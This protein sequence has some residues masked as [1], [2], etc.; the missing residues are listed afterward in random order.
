MVEIETE[1]FISELPLPI[2]DLNNPGDINDVDIDIYHESE[3]NVQNAFQPPIQLQTMNNTLSGNSQQNNLQFPIQSQIIA[4]VPLINPQKNVL[5]SPI[6]SQ[7]MGNLSS[8]NLQQNTLQPA[9]QSQNTRGIPI[10]SNI[11]VKPIIFQPPSIS[12][13][14][15][16]N[17]SSVSSTSSKQLPSPIGQINIPKNLFQQQI[18]SDKVAQVGNKQLSPIIFNQQIKPQQTSP[19]IFQQQS[20]NEQKINIFQPPINPLEIKPQNKILNVNVQSPFNMIKPQNISISQNQKQ[21]IEQIDNVPLIDKISMDKYT[22]EDIKLFNDNPHIRQL[23]LIGEKPT[24]NYNFQRTMTDDYP[25]LPYIPFTK[26]VKDANPTISENE[27]EENNRDCSLRTVVHWGQRKLLISEIEFLTD[28]L[29]IDKK[30]IVV[31]VGAAPGTHITY[32]YDLFLNVEFHLYDPV[33]FKIRENDRIKIFNKIFTEE[34]ANN[35]KG[36][37]VLL[38]SDIRSTGVENVPDSVINEAIVRDNKAQE[39]W[40]DIMQPYKALLKF[41][42]PYDVGETKY[43]DGDVY[44]QAWAPVAS[45][46]TR[47][48]PNGGRKIYNHVQYESKMS[49]YNNVSR[50]N[51]Y[52]H[53]IISTQLDHCYDCKCEIYIL[54]K[55]LLKYTNAYSPETINSMSEDIT[56]FICPNNERNLRTANPS[57]TERLKSLKK[58]TNV[59]KHSGYA[60]GKNKIAIDMVNK[61]IKD[62]NW[63]NYRE[64][65]TIS[66][67]TYNKIHDLL[68]K[69]KS[70]NKNFREVQNYRNVKIYAADGDKQET[71]VC[72]YY[73]SNVICPIF[74]YLV[75]E[76]IIAIGEYNRYYYL[77]YNGTYVRTNVRFNNHP[78]DPNKILPSLEHILKK[79]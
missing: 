4:N 53:D 1:G 33:A 69:I 26:R 9:F 19:I 6:K 46:E 62:D 56:T 58:L 61:Y 37:P 41:R 30:Y 18:I 5:Q 2:I 67:E 23:I 72:F 11:P 10:L 28:N 76:N 50:V 3:L 14:I 66:N 44:F 75:D 38:I 13:T 52:P 65:D 78:Q 12:Q 45:T 73:S 63:G 7:T 70:I 48:V 59:G 77:I 17:V 57:S 36:Q 24:I 8:S 64:I 47:L 39:S 71:Y 43:L 22:S 31:Y 54:S 32:L 60:A 34:D 25:E 49:Y 79:L 20:I 74:G 42:F 35:Y 27:I 29:D 40:Y 15:T 68:N 21:N 55:Y 51:I 16:S